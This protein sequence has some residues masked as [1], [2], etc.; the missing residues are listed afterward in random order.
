MGKFTV[1]FHTEFLR[2]HL[3]LK[4][5]PFSG[6]KEKNVLKRVLKIFHTF[7]PFVQSMG[8]R[9]HDNNEIERRRYF[10]SPEKQK[11]SGNV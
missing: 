1:P 4:T 10:F 6:K 3:G 7:R 11:F 9:S 2:S 5:E 8:L